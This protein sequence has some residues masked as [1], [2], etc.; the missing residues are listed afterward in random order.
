MFSWGYWFRPY[1]KLFCWLFRFLMH[2][3]RA[4]SPPHPI[5]FHLITIKFL[6][7]YRSSFNF[8]QLPLCLCDKGSHRN[9]WLPKKELLRQ[10][11]SSFLD[12]RNP[13]PFLNLAAPCWKIITE[14]PPLTSVVLNWSDAAATTAARRNRLTCLKLSQIGKW[15]QQESTFLPAFG[16]FERVYLK[17]SHGTLLENHRTKETKWQHKT[18][19]KMK[20]LQF[21]LGK[22]IL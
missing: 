20:K 22:T 18:V 14:L 7:Y 12:S 21:N 10:W 9:G 16:L 1:L 19:S 4:V 6:H 5:S 15:L 11:F 3:K 13:S 8:M 17:G 2:G